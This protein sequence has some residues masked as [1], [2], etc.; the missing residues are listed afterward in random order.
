VINLQLS[1]PKTYLCLC[2]E[3][4]HTPLS[5]Y[6]K[7]HSLTS[8]SQTF[9]PICSETFKDA[10]SVSFRSVLNRRSP[11]CGPGGFNFF[12]TAGTHWAAKQHR[13]IPGHHCS[14]SGMNRISSVRP[15]G[16]TV[17]NR[18]K[19]CQRWRYSDSRLE[20]GVTEESRR[21]RLLPVKLLFGTIA[22]DECR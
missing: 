5:D 3:R 11:G 10:R 8:T 6:K 14:S 22:F 13:L 9:S 17:S 15:L 20:H 16:E 12:S 7:A 19:L 21:S 1:L 4:P 2:I 18:N